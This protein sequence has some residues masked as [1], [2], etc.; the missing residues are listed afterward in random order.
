[1]LR[2]YIGHSQVF[3]EFLNEFL[4]IMLR[5]EAIAHDQTVNIL[6]LFVGGGLL[7]KMMELVC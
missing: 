5:I 2:Y 6:E 7:D 4:L 1:M 3:E